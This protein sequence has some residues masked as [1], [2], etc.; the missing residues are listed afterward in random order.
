[1]NVIKPILAAVLTLAATTAMADEG[2]YLPSD[3]AGVPNS[4]FVTDSKTGQVR[5]CYFEG[6]EEAMKCSPWSEEE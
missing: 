3:V 5:I 4:L 2:R 6:F 1:M